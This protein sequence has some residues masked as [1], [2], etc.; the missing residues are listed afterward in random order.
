[1][2]QAR[3]KD[4]HHTAS[5]MTELYYNDSNITECGKLTTVELPAYLCSGII[6]RVAVPGKGYNSWNPSPADESSGGVSFSYIRKD[7]KFKGFE[8]GK[9]SGFTL[10]PAQGTYEGPDSKRTLNVECAFPLD[11]LTQHR[12]APIGCGK[13]FNEPDGGEAGKICQEQGI[14]TAKE[15]LKH[16][17]ESSYKNP[18]LYQ[19]GFDVAKA[20]YHPAAA[21]MQMIAAMKLLGDTS[22][23][24]NNELRLHVW[25]KEWNKELPIQSFFYMGDKGSTAWT[26]AQTDQKSVLRADQ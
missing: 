13:P 21:F 12:G 24:T 6:I 25:P 18:K 10:Y 23:D 2:T 11:G 1:M 4:T 3:V 9:A 8:I 15:W 26:N 14:T 16:Y 22:F 17:H 7:S 5:D 19:C 20:K